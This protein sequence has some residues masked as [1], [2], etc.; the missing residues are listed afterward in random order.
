MQIR[1][2]PDLE[3]H[4]RPGDRRIC[5][6]YLHRHYTRAGAGPLPSTSLGWRPAHGCGVIPCR[7]RRTPPSRT[8]PRGGTDMTRLVALAMA[9]L[10]TAGIVGLPAVEA[11]TSK[12]APPAAE[13]A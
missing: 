11:Q 5:M 9:L 7:G 12:P 2:P 6:V 13:P 3:E 8:E 4:A 10:F 1:L